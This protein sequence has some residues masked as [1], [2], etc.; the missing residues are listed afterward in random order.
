MTVADPLP[1]QRDAIEEII[2]REA[3]LVHHGTGTGK[4][5]TA[6]EAIDILISVG[7]SP[8]LHVVPNSLIE[9]TVEEYE[10]WLGEQ[11]CQRRLV[12]LDSKLSLNQRAEALG[13]LSRAY[14]GEVYLLSTEALSHKLIREG[15][16]RREW[17]AAF[18]DEGSRYR[19]YSARTRTLQVLG[20]KAKTR[21]VF[22]GNIMPRNP[23]DLWY[24]MN[25]LVPRIFGTS[26]IQTFKSEYCVLGGFTGMNVIGIRPDRI[27]KLRAIVDAH[28]VKAE[29][30]DVRADMP[31]RTLTTRHVALCEG[32][33]SRT[34]CQMRDTLRAEIERMTAEEFRTQASTYSVRLLRLQEI[35]AGFARNVEGD[36]E[37]IGSNKTSE[38]VET[39]LDTPDTPTIIWYW[40][41]PE[42]TLIEAALAKAGLSWITFEKAGDGSR[43]RF[44]RGD[45][46]IYISQLAKGAYGLNLTRAER[47]IYHSLPWDLDAYLQSQER[48]MRLTTTAEHLEIE[49]LVVRGTVDEYVRR[50]LLAKAGISRQLSRSDALAMLR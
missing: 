32:T 35:A 40:W 9:Q 15:I 2:A 29:L 6:I 24:I 44:M 16:R 46:D 39:L 13:G 19:N 25:F 34:Y 21:Y 12:V 1:H 43:D 10:T 7:E 49:H 11:W 8:V 14:Q 20:Q 41:Q 28:S 33:Q 27:A 3:L 5:R 23:A 45:A 47:M 30:S 31:T 48:N 22:S 18:I 42:K 37:Y 36:V 4:T 50:K 38:M 26:N 17:G